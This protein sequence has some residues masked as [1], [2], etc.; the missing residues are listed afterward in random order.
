MELTEDRYIVALRTNGDRDGDDTDEIYDW[1]SSDAVTPDK[2]RHH[3]PQGY[4]VLGFWPWSAWD[5]V[6]MT[7]TANMFVSRAVEEMR[8]NGRA[9]MRHWL[10]DT[11]EE[12]PAPRGR[13]PRVELVQ[14]WLEKQDEA[15]L[16]QRAWEATQ[17]MGKAGLI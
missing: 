7:E 3:I 13:K 4:T 9:N 12:T 8:R 16:A 17:A 14:D 11:E 10:E 5:R 2:L 6:R 1:G 15:S